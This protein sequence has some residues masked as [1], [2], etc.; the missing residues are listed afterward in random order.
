[1]ASL[2]AILGCSGILSSSGKCNSQDGIEICTGAN[3][4]RP[5]ADVVLRITNSSQRTVYLDVCSIQVTGKATESQEFDA[6]YNPGR[7]CGPGVSLEEIVAQMRELTPG[8]SLNHTV[9][10]ST[11]VFQGDYR[12]NVWFL[13]ET[14][15]R[16]FEQPVTTAVFDVFPSAR[17]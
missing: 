6:Q 1:M 3:E 9:H 4:Y 16:L 14:G 12:I 2:L 15:Q 8:S 5:G 17:R 11:G 10:I 13:D 7:R